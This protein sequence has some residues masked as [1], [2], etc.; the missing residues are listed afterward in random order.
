[1]TDARESV[2]RPRRGDVIETGRWGRGTV[3]AVRDYGRTL[4]V[5][6]APH[7]SPHG[8]ETVVRAAG[9]WWV[10]V[11]RSAERVRS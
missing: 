3:V 5:D 4:D 8:V 1:M 10:R 6:L 9:G 11:A 2:R 7:G